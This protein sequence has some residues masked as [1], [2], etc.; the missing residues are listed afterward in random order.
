VLPTNT[1]P[2]PPPAGFIYAMEA[3]PP[4]P[5]INTQ[6]QAYPQAT[7]YPY[8]AFPAYGYPYQPPSYTQ[9]QNGMN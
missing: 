2:A 1:F 6:P 5:G 8:Q 3:P 9:E 7:A 4:Y